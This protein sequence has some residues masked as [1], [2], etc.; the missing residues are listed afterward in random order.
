MNR[1]SSGENFWKVLEGWHRRKSQIR[2]SFTSE[3]LDVSFVAVVES[4]VTGYSISLRRVDT[5]VLSDPL[6]L[7]DADI[8]VASLPYPVEKA[9]GFEELEYGFVFNIMLPDDD[10]T[11]LSL[12]EIRDFGGL[13]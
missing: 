12:A 7:H 11:R 8:R 2:V 13:V 3:L 6:D 1:R 10:E 5:G 9:T 4:F